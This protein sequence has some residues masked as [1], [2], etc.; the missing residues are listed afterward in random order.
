MQISVG[1][2]E[3]IA[4]AVGG[5]LGVAAAGGTYAAFTADEPSTRRAGGIVA[6][7]ALLGGA[8]LGAA[9]LRSGAGSFAAMGAVGF[10]GLPAVVGT[11][12]LQTERDFG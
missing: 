4:A 6:G 8:G 2:R 1:A 9:L 10:V 3:M 11:G 12:L 5:L 7:A